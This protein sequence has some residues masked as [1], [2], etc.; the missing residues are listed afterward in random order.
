M[1]AVRVLAETIVI[2]EDLAALRR[3][4]LSAPVVV[5]VVLRT[6]AR[7]AARALVVKARLVERRQTFPVQLCSVVK[8]VGRRVTS[9]KVVVVRFPAVVGMARSAVLALAGATMA[10]V[11]K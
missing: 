9:R 7:T 2:L 10:A 8:M 4:S 3:S 6:E 11:V 1:S 5:V